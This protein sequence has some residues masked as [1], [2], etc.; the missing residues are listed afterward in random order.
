[1]AT[2]SVETWQLGPHQGLDQRGFALESPSSVLEAENMG[3]LTESFI[4]MRNAFTDEDLTSAGFTGEI[5][6]LGRHVTDDGVEELW[7][8]ANNAGTVACARKVAGTWTTVTLIDTPDSGNLSQ[9]HSVSFNG[10]LFLAY[11]SDVNRLHVWDGTS[12]RRVG[13]TVSGVGSVAD[14]GSGSY[15]ATARRYRFSQ[16]IKSGTDII[17]ESELSAAVS[18]TP[19]GSGTAARIT[20]P[21]A[22]DS[23]THWVVYGLISSAGDTYDLYEELA[24]TANATTTYDDSTAP[25]SYAGDAPPELNSNIPPPS[26]KFLATDSSRVIMAGAWE[27]T[28][29]AGQ[30]TPKANRVWFSRPLAA[31]DVGDDES[32]PNGLW[33]NI[34]DAGPVTGLGAIYTDVYVFKFGSTHKLVPTQ[35]PDGPF[36]RVIVS[37][38]FGA[39]GQRVIANGETEDGFSAIYFADDHAVYRL[40]Y[41]AVVPFSEP[42]GRDTRIQPITA[43]GS[44]LAYD[45]YRR[46]LVIQISNSVLSVTGVYSAFLTDAVKKKWSGFSLG[47]LTSGWTLGTGILGTDTTLAGANATIRAAVVATSQDGVLKLYTGGKTAGAASLLRSWG[48][49]NGLDGS[50]A[51]TTKVRARRIFGPGKRATIWNPTVFYRNPQG[52]TVGTMTCA[53]SFVKNYDDETRSQSFTMTA[54]GDDNGISIEEKLMESLEMSDVSVLDCIVTL[55]YSGTAYES[56]TTP[57]IDA[58]VTPIKI[59]ER[60]GQ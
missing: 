25:A 40:A 10:K 46:V 4:S 30:T 48:K 47:G 43:D 28:A 41:G 36:S 50:V 2:P 16:R 56:V 31:T 12:V 53:V 49:R 37:E 26:A 20:Q 38:N 45:P 29:S 13:L 33:L 27:T 8:A 52:S 60:I 14:T 18:F 6:W 9:M 5:Q 32:V 7:S 57:T 24:E 17:A 3:F 54:T 21:T 22:V 39:V 23:A 51:F 44:V 34:G 59:Q 15:T 1:M 35:D 55:T 58:I 19:S 42:V 11:D